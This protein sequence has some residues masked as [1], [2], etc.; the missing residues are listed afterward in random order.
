MTCVD[1]ALRSIWRIARSLPRK[2]ERRRNRHMRIDGPSC[3]RIWKFSPIFRVG[4]PERPD[5]HRLLD[6]SL[7]PEFCGP[8]GLFA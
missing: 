6:D 1:R 8:G 3:R 2:P 5:V 4:T 7:D